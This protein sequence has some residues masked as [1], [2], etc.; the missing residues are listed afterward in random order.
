MNLIDFFKTLF[1]AFLGLIIS[2][3]SVATPPPAN[4]TENISPPIATTSIIGEKP[5]STTTQKII[6]DKKKPSTPKISEPIPTQ[7]NLSRGSLILQDKIGINFNDL[8]EKVRTVLVNIICTTKIGGLFKPISGSGVLIDKRGVILTNAHI[9]QYFLLKNYMIPDFLTCVIRTGS[10]AYPRYTADLL[11]VSP[12]W[13]NEHA[14]DITAQ[15]P[16]GTGQYDYALLLITRAI[17]E[18]KLPDSFPSLAYNPTENGYKKGTPVVLASYPA[19]FLGGIN[20]QQNLYIA[21]SVGTIDGIFTF[22][23]NTFDLF[24]VSGSIVAQKGASGGAIVGTD[25]QLIGVIATATDANN[26]SER[27]LQAIT[28]GHIE[29]SLNEE[30]TMNLESFLS[31]DLNE[32]LQSFQKTLAPAL[33]EVLVKELNKVN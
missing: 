8:N 10:P 18:E 30:M 29:R 11:Y 23:E 15:E 17:A 33:T 27:S 22:K 4:L 26:T 9:G 1:A 20:I 14:S 24:S 16:L 6:P 19:G 25:G 5:A 32:R 28:I 12:R 31:G 3:F 7:E 21:S 13:I 2:I